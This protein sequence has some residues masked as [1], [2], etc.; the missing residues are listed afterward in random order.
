MEASRGQKLE[1]GEIRVED[2]YGLHGGLVGPP[3]VQSD[4]ET[5]IQFKNIVMTKSQK[6]PTVQCWQ[7]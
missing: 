7:C 1:F 3:V 2:V 5:Q 4:Q 6:Q